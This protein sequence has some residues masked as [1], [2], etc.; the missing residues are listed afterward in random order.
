MSLIRYCGGKV[1]QAKNI[2]PSIKIIRRKSRVFCEPFAGGGSVSLAVAERYSLTG[3]QIVMNDLD[4]GVWA[5]W[6]V[7]S[8]SDEGMFKELRRRLTSTKPTIDLFWE[9]RNAKHDP[10]DILELA[11]Q[12]F[13]C[14]RTCRIETHGQR[15]M[16]AVTERW[17]QGLPQAMLVARRILKGRTTV[18]NIDAMRLIRE[19]EADW[20]FYCDPPYFSVGNDIYIQYPMA[21]EQHIELRDALRATSADWV[22]SYDGLTYIEEIYKDFANIEP[23]EVQ[24]SMSPRKELATEW[25]ITPKRSAL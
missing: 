9:I 12:F 3:V 15:P 14:N 4:P 1:N 20:S 7:I 11:W 13:Y 10:N 8:G 19:A 5:F 24:Y 17:C 16:T 6:N 21:P 23:L 2:V 18:L 22:L 25:L